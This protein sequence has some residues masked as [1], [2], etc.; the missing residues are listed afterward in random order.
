MYCDWMPFSLLNGEQDDE[1]AKAMLKHHKGLQGHASWISLPGGRWFG[2]AGW[3]GGKKNAKQAHGLAATLVHAAFLSDTTCLARFDRTHIPIVQSAIKHIQVAYLDMSI[4][5]ASPPSL[6]DAKAWI[7]EA[8]AKGTICEAFHADRPWCEV[9]I[10][11]D[12]LRWTQRD[13]HTEFS[14]VLQ[15]RRVPCVSNLA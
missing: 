1:L 12:L 3:S 8:E 9:N 13:C 2:V 4:R 15:C 7:V 10:P 6:E 14:G 11:V 5:I